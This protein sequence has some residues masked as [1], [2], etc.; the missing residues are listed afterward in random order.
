ML[1][2]SP[3]NDTHLRLFASRLHTSHTNRSLS[4]TRLSCGSISKYCKS[5][6]RQDRIAPPMIRSYY[7]FLAGSLEERSS[8]TTS[9]EFRAW[10]TPQQRANSCPERI[11]RKFLLSSPRTRLVSVRHSALLSVRF[12]TKDDPIKSRSRVQAV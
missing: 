12:A 6:T 10:Y 8:P 2:A 7:L 1:Y 3:T 4:S 5:N 11:L 9:G